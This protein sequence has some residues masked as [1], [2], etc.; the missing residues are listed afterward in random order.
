MKLLTAAL[1]AVISFT[2][3]AVLRAEDKAARGKQ[4]FEEQKCKICHRIDGVGNPKGVLDDVGSKHDAETLRMWLTKPQEMAKKAGATRK[5]PMRS[6]EK[7]PKEDLDA[8]IAYLS[9]LKKKS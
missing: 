7:V 1:A 3:V 6:F 5:P 4:V 2:L 9:T 8:L